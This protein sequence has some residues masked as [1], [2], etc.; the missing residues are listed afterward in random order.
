M[1]ASRLRG[2][3]VPEALVPLAIDE[4]PVLFVAAACAEGETL[5][6]GAHELRVKESDRLAVMAE[7]LGALGVEHELLPDGIW[8]Q[9]GAGFSGGTVDS[10]GDHRIAMAFAVAS[11]RA[12][13]APS[14]FATSP[15]SP[16]PSRVSCRPRA[17][18]ACRSTRHRGQRRMP[19]RMP[20][21]APIVTID[22]PSG[23]GKGTISRAVAQPRSA[24]I[25]STAARSTAWPRWPACAPG[26]RPTT[27]RATRSSR[28]TMDVDFR[29]RART[30]A[31]SSTL[32]GQDVTARAAV[33]SGRA[34]RLARRGLARRSARR[35]WRASTPSPG[36]RAWSRTGGTWAPWYSRRA[37][38][39]IFLT[40]SAEE[41]ALRR[42]KQLKD[43][44][45]DVSLAALSREIA[46]RDLRD[47]TRAVAPLKP[48]PD[49]E[50]IDSTGLT[51]EE[52]VDRV[53]E[54]GRRR[55]LWRVARRKGAVLARLLF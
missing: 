18:P 12:P 26:S 44:G 33:G 20:C 17:A 15:T 1:R 2:I 46:E 41:R 25:C 3:T 8:I 52:V 10:H 48:A 24:G 55:S 39:K 5:V 28:R 6:R 21:P 32:D 7:G 35:C 13:Q 9:G 45:S 27:C 23:S 49:A 11:V 19:L 16:P 51:I 4:F 43:K 54:I 22:G 36:P 30:A 29:R 40:A 14:R 50:V 53:L 38:L 47:S 37:D 34:G 42:Y 31:S